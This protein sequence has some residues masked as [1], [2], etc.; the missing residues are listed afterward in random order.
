MLVSAC[1]NAPQGKQ[2]ACFSAPIIVFTTNL[3]RFCVKPQ[4]LLVIAK[5][6]E[7]LTHIVERAGRADAVIRLSREGKRFKQRSKGFLVTFLR[8]IC[9]AETGQSARLTDDLIRS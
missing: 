8:Q 9:E 6:F 1:S 5:S 3:E 4:S 7:R 2:T